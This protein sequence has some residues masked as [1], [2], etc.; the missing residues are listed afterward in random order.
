MPKPGQKPKEIKS[1][2][3]TTL[4]EIKMALKPI[5]GDAPSKV[6]NVTAEIKW[7]ADSDSGVDKVTGQS[8][9]ATL[10]GV[11][12][13]GMNLV[14]KRIEAYEKIKKSTEELDDEDKIEHNL[15]VWDINN[16]RFNVDTLIRQRLGGQR[17]GLRIRWSVKEGCFEFDPYQKKLYKV[18]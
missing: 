11:L 9:D 10:G 2:I 4:D 7:Q 13:E 6:V 16:I 18:D 3:V 1:V 14:K 12:I 17:V 8:I 15:V 5:L